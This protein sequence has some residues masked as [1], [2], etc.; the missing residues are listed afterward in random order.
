MVYHSVEASEISG[1]QLD[2]AVEVARG[3][4][5][6]DNGQLCFVDDQGSES[7][8]D[9]PRY[10]YSTNPKIAREL[11]IESG[12]PINI[13]NVR[14]YEASGAGLLVAAMRCYVEIKLGHRVCVPFP[15]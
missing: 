1:Y 12:I 9:T 10:E 13:G 3:A 6:D 8:T 11:L 2:W 4:T 7:I 14:E 15:E 5:V